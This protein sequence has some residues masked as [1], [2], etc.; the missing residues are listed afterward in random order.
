MT[1]H[2]FMQLALLEAEKAA[3]LGEIPI[4]AIIVRDGNLIASAHNQKE[5]SNDPT[6]HAEILAI[7]QAALTL[8]AWRLENCKLF[9]TLEP[10]LMCSGAILQ[11]RI[12][13]V[14]FATRDPKGGAVISCCESFNTPNINHRPKWQEGVMQVEAS[15]LLKNFF[16]ELRSSK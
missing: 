9:V 2:D 14:I 3:K 16:K 12:S 4:G 8:G 11:S 10:C 7:K 13:E 15:L 5:T 6:D 1:D